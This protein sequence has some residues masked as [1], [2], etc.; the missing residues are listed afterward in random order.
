[1]VEPEH[2]L[3]TRRSDTAQDIE[4]D[5]ATLE[6]LEAVIEGNLHGFTS[7][8]AALMVIQDRKLYLKTHHTWELY[9]AERW[10]MNRMM[11]WRQ[12]TQAKAAKA[13]PQGTPAPSQRAA[14]AANSRVTHGLS[15]PPV[16]SPSSPKTR[17]T[18][19][20]P[21]LPEPELPEAPDEVHDLLDEL[22]PE[23]A[24]RSATPVDWLRKVVEANLKR[25]AAS[26]PT[27]APPIRPVREKY[28]TD[29]NT[30]FKKGNK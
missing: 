30:F 25:P 11:A 10:G 20:A 9:L 7:A 17:Y 2:D 5:G 8:A 14:A 6:Q 26:A 22:W 29:V 23:I 16:A 28:Q 12:I 21:E 3:R 24:A 15:A 4:Q 1:M 13:L 27:K 19:T 18:V